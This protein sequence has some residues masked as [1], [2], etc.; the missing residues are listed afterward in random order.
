[1][2]HGT[3]GSENE[4][5]KTINFSNVEPVDQLDVN[6]INDRKTTAIF[7]RHWYYPM[8]YFFF[9]VDGVSYFGRKTLSKLYLDGKQHIKKCNQITAPM[10]IG[11]VLRTQTTEKGVII[12][13]KP[14][15]NPEKVY[16]FSQ[17]KNNPTIDLYFPFP[18]LD[19]FFKEHVQSSEAWDATEDMKDTLD[20][21]EEHIRNYT[22]DFLAQFN[23]D[24]K[25]VYD[26]ACS[27]GKFIGTI[28][29]A[30]P[31]IRAIGQ[32][33][34]HQMIEF[35]KTRGNIDELHVGSALYPCVPKDSVDII[36]LRFLN[37]AVLSSDAALSLFCKL[38]D[39]CKTN[40][41]I[42]VFGYTPVLISA[43]ICE[44]LNL[45]MKQTTAYSKENDSIFQ[46]YVLE[47]LGP[48]PQLRYE[49]FSTYN[50]STAQPGL[51]NSNRRL[52]EAEEQE[53]LPE[54]TMR[55]KL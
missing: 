5:F 13:Y 24:N 49:K 9:K 21:G 22:L 40:G 37:L 3:R 25:V 53:K 44:M 50:I 7:E 1:M 18:V 32:D 31:T 34:N 47:K 39:C 12:F 27:T 15:V 48:V 42:V 14:L 45:K 55:S 6:A 29:S 54:N 43:E 35:A 38:A 19:R 46:Y 51:F 8:D 28:K 4:Y 23:M 26:P 30:Y 10:V 20:V 41:T 52:K 17:L 36:F 11:L 2:P 16:L 33:M